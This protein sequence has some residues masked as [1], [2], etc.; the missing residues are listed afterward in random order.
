MKPEFYKKEIYKKRPATKKEAKAQLSAIMDDMIIRDNMK[1]RFLLEVAAAAIFIQLL[2][3]LIC[4]GVFHLNN[5]ILWNVYG[6]IFA[7]IDALLGTV[8]CN[9]IRGLI[10]NK[11]AYRNVKEQTKNWSIKEDIITYTNRMIDAAL[12]DKEH[13]R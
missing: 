6:I 7:L 12:D 3:P 4:T 11:K 2:I 9:L 8:I 5:S 13:G 10:R 1:I